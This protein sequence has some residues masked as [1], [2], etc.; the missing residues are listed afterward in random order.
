MKQI[1]TESKK[2]I[3][4][5]LKLKNQD[6]KSLGGMRLGTWNHYIKEAKKILKK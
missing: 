1:K 6:L 2:V 3:E 4:L 5:A